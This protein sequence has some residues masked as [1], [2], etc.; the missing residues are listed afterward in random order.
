MHDRPADRGAWLPGSS[1][2]DG[3][4]SNRDHGGLDYTLLM[5]V[6]LFWVHF[7]ADKKPNTQLGAG[8][9]CWLIK[10]FLLIVW[11]KE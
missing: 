1:A 6:I 3:E 9:S 2:T 5:A 8:L 11:N 10:Q 4:T 7:F